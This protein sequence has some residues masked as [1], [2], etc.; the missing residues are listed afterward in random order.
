[1]E[2]KRYSDVVEYLKRDLVTLSS[3]AQNAGMKNWAYPAA[4]IP[5]TP[6]LDS[7]TAHARDVI[8]VSIY[9]TKLN[10]E[11]END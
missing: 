7:H 8:V 11:H 3:Q 2:V 9:R 5:S 6:L 1:M 4:K 10:V